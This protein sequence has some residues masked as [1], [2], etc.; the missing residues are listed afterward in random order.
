MQIE[1]AEI[2]A[3]QL[4]TLAVLAKGQGLGS[5]THMWL[6]TIYLFQFQGFDALFLLLWAHM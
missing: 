1:A 6:A 3:L 5:S 2:M 4:R